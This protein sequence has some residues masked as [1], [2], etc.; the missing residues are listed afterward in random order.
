MQLALCEYVTFLVTEM[1]IH[2][3][4]K[5][6]SFSSFGSS[7]VWNRWRLTADKVIVSHVIERLILL[8]GWEVGREAG[9]RDGR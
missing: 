6:G 3:F 5:Q 7:F 2:N 4:A 9:S 1:T 8:D